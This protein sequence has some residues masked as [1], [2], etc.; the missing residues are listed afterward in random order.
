MYH[1]GHE[2]GQPSVKCF[3]IPELLPFLVFAVDLW[4]F[5]RAGIL[6]VLPIYWAWHGRHSKQYMNHFNGCFSVAF[7]CIFLPWIPKCFFLKWEYMVE[8][9]TIWL[10]VSQPLLVPNWSQC[11]VPLSPGPGLG[12]ACGPWTPGWGLALLLWSTKLRC[13]LVY[14]IL[15][16]GSVVS[17]TVV[18]FS[19]VNCTVV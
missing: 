3:A 14:S 8:D 2:W 11:R 9:S 5:Q 13:T 10:Q 17:R 4:F 19:V 1:P 7:K 6:V 12:P 16:Y 15:V 18:H